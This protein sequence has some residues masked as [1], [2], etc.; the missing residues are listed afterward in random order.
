HYTLYIGKDISERF[1][2]RNAVKAASIL[3]QEL[4]KMIKRDIPA[5]MWLHKRF[6]TRPEGLDCVYT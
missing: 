5:W 2:R 4:E 3:N 6:K 1:E